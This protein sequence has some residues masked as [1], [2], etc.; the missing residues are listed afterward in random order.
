M[1][2]FT[3]VQQAFGQ[4][5]CAFGART[6]VAVTA[7]TSITIPEGFWLIETDAHE[8]VRFTYDGGTTFV[9][10]L[11]VSS[12]GQLYSDGQNVHFRSDATG[13]TGH[14]SKVLALD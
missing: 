6:A 14:Y 10:M 3:G 7:S 4:A 8:T 13:G 2:I 12:V 11:A 1:P 9:T 5:G